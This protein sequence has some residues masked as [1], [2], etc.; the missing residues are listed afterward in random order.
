LPRIFKRIGYIYSMHWN[1]RIF[2]GLIFPL[3]S[4][5]SLELALLARISHKEIIPLS[6]GKS[7]FGCELWAADTVPP[8]GGWVIFGFLLLS[9]ALR[10]G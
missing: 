8:G 7:A 2:A 6:D 10:R 1:F 5:A 3:N 9:V 4:P